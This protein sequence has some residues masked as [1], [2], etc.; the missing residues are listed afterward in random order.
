MYIFLSPNLPIDDNNNLVDSSGRA[1]I[2]AFGLNDLTPPQYGEHQFD[3]LYSE[4]DPSGYVTP[5]GPRSGLTTPFQGRSRSVS[6]EGV[7]VGA[8]D[9]TTTSGIPVS[10]LQSRLNS[11]N[12]A[13]ATAIRIPR[14]RSQL[15]T[16]G[17][18]IQG[19]N[20]SGD[21]P[22]DNVLPRNASAS[23]AGYFD[24][25][26]GTPNGHTP[27]E[28]MNRRVSEEEEELAPSHSPQHVEFSAE[29]LAKVPSYTTALRSNPRTPIN[30]GLPSYYTAVQIP[31]PPSRS[32]SNAF[33]TQAGRG[34]I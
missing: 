13:G 7:S 2:S 31:L 33:L 15:A 22:V 27:G 4:I 10:V 16:S 14:D 12:M 28:N 20:G 5:G 17:D 25:R 34:S 26:E 21:S 19:Q 23:Q 32:C 8:E 6:A 24:N 29:D 1:A 3:Q 30:E 11:L 18:G 9:D